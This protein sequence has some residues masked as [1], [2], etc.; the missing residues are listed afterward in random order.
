MS[1][2]APL[3]N[4]QPSDVVDSVAMSTTHS[5]AGSSRTLRS[6]LLSGAFW[7]TLGRICSVGALFA[8][9]ICMG[10]TL[11]VSDC[12]AYFAVSAFVVLLATGVLFGTPQIVIRAIKDNLKNGNTEDSRT[13]VR[14]CFAA[15]TI[16]SAI[17]LAIAI[18]SSYAVGDEP[19]WRAVRE[20]SLLVGIWACCSAACQI[21]AGVLQALDDFRSA[22]L[23]GARQGGVVANSL[24]LVI[25][26]LAYQA[27]YLSLGF[28]LVLQVLLNATALIIAWWLIERAL[29]NN[30]ERCRT[31]TD[32][33][34]T[35]HLPQRTNY[36]VR[37]I[38][39]E[40]WPN[41]LV[42]MTSMNI[43]YIQVLVLGWLATARSTA[44]YYAV[45]RLVSLV[46]VA[47]LLVV[48]T[49]GPFIAE[50]L[51]SNR[52][53]QLERI[54]RGV[55]TLVAIPTLLATLVLVVFPKTVIHLTFGDDF[56]GAALALQI[57]A[58]GTAISV[59]TGC[60]SVA[61]VM[62]GYQ[63][64]LMRISL[65]AFVVHF[66]LIVPMIDKWDIVGAALA[67]T[68]V[69]GIY[70]LYVTFLVKRNLGFWSY[71]SLSPQAIRETFRA[72]T[73]RRNKPESHPA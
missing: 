14:K 70:N 63:S 54:M 52:I 10:R 42:Q 62:G 24:F 3:I 53:K 43:V 16:T 36:S 50:L 9:E 37:W 60:N 2:E 58:V 48:A 64:L 49:L 17:A 73:Q 71:P 12:A 18:M 56:V 66:L 57:V 67:A 72:L 45:L 27:G 4:K 32:M 7:S 25:S 28:A 6:R 30:Q 34:T 41:F 22:V 47:Q 29:N 19:K 5:E 59:I 68:I 8:T 61:M 55:A 13:V 39:Q 65:L 38:L 26:L 44:D 11:S 51:A 1:T 23:I 40:S 15:I 33:P 20:L 69:Y 21:A 46:Q 35:T 31:A